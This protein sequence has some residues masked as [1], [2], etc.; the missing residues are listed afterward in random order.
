M[1]YYRNIHN[2]GNHWTVNIENVKLYLKKK[3][4][5]RAGNDGEE[6]TK[7]RENMGQLFK[8]VLILHKAV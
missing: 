3:T 6:I 1:Q 4:S 7:Q 5:S 2:K 8:S